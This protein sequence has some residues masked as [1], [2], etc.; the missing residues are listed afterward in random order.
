M[1]VGVFPTKP[2]WKIP[3]EA[4]DPDPVPKALKSYRPEEVG[5][6]L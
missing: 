4:E 3:F 1:L 6:N 2:I 5:V